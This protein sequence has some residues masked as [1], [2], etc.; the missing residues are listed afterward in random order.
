MTATINLEI[1]GDLSP[2]D[3]A[4]ALA[5]IRRL[6]G[7]IRRDFPQVT[8]IYPAEGNE[9]GGEQS[10]PMDELRPFI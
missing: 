10:P 3:R 5:V 9:K 7:V 6:R 2:A 1:V 4:L 8:V